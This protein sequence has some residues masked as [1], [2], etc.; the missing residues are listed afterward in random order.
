MAEA[1]AVNGDDPLARREL[2]NEAA[3]GEV[4][5]HRAVT[6]DQH[7]G[8]ALTSGNVVDPQPIHLDEPAW[9][10]M[11]LLIVE[12]LHCPSSRPDSP[13]RL[14]DG[15]VPVPN[16]SSGG[17]GRGL[18]GLGGVLGHEAGSAPGGLSDQA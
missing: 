9:R 5:G 17:F 3:D 8:T 18:Q 1:G 16:C 11:D 2:V 7:H 12:G 10:A 14:L 4:L 13:A 6:V 15:L